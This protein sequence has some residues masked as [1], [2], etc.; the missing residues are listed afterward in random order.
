MGQGRPFPHFSRGEGRE[1]CTCRENVNVQE[2]DVH[3]TWNLS[4]ILPLYPELGD[5]GDVIMEPHMGF[6]FEFDSWKCNL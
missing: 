6:E 3:L 2:K 5:L 4:V 1:L